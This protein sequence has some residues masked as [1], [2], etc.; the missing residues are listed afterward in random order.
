MEKLVKEMESLFKRNI[1]N[2]TKDSFFELNEITLKNLS[3]FVFYSLKG[4]MNFV[5]DKNEPTYFFGVP[6]KINENLLDNQL[7]LNIK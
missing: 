7:K 3:E 5:F 1:W 2:I 4:D 6:V